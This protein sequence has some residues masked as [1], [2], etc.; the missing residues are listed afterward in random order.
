MKQYNNMTLLTNIN[1][2]QKDMPLRRRKKRRKKVKFKKLTIKLTKRQMKSLMNYC[3][4]RQTTPVRLIKRAI[5]RYTENYANTV[6]DKY[7]VT[8]NQLDLFEEANDNDLI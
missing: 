1:N 3:A 5:R 7:Y 8:E 2:R 4:A 6:P